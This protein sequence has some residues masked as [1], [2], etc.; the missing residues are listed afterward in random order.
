MELSTQK[1]KVLLAK[2]KYQLQ[3]STGSFKD[4]LNKDILK[5]E[6]ELRSRLN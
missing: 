2:K 5:L 6:I 1:I 3:N 4:E